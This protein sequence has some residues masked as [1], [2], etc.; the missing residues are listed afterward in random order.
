MPKVAKTKEN[1]KKCQC[2]NCPSYTIGCKMKN[3]PLNF[4]RMIDGLDNLEHFE[5]MFCAYGSS[6][7]IEENRGCLCDDCEVFRENN[8][9]RDEY[10]LPT[11]KAT[12]RCHGAQCRA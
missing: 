2:R 6:N 11:Q 8:L 12:L 10:C 3:Y 4:I 7:C 1:L 9:K 5:G